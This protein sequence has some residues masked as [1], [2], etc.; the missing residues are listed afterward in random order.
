MITLA[1]DLKTADVNLK[2]TTLGRIA[3]WFDDQHQEFV[4]KAVLVHRKSVFQILI[5]LIR[6]CPVDTGRLRGSWAPFLDKYGQIQRALKWAQT[7]SPMAGIV[8]GER[9]GFNQE[10]FDEGKREGTIIDELFSTTL[11]SNVNYVQQVNARVNFIGAAKVWGDRR[12][13]QNFENFFEAMEKQGIVP[14]EDD[15]SV[16]PNVGE[17]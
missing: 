11:T 16:D 15:P 9:E 2:D 10:A 3:K 13:N 17:Q 14:G 1:Y 7:Q 5:Y 6:L 4:D 12:Y 8:K